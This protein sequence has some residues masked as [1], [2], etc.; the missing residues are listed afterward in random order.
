VHQAVH[1]FLIAEKLRTRNVHS[2]IVFC[3]SP[4]NNISESFRRFGLSD[5]T[6]SLICIKISSPQKPISS[7]DVERYLAEVV[8]GTPVEFS[9]DAIAQ[10]TDSARVSK[11]Y[12]M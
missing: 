10:E 5:T 7:A 12:K 1:K 4:N 8:K 2:E 11:C 6:T 3:L 9:D